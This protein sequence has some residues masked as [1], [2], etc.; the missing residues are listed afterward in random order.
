M[1]LWIED[2][3]CDPVC[4]ARAGLARPCPLP[5]PR[6]RDARRSYRVPVREQFTA[7][8]L[9]GDTTL[10]AAVT[11]LSARGAAVLID[12]AEDGAERLQPGTV[13]RFVFTRRGRARP[14]RSLASVQQ[15]DEPDQGLVRLGLE[16]QRLEELYEQLDPEV[17]PFFNRRRSYRVG[18]ATD[19]EA[20]RARAEGPQEHRRL[21]GVLADL[22]VGGCA[23]AVP[24]EVPV[25]FLPGGGV[26]LRFVPPG[27][28]REVSVAARTVHRRAERERNLVGFAFEP[29]GVPGWPGIE[30]DLQ[31][32]VME[33][34][35][36]ELASGAEDQ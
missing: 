11:D 13:H 14:I 33:V 27:T 16:F 5:L 8:V 9:L 31:R 32:H 2:R 29:E 6:D 3:A 23:L 30:D 17:W 21:E 19:P 18:H 12:P 36:R 28:R 20:P 15:R 25:L 26:E 24:R 35:R 1:T 22:S 34:Q 10:G 7:N 4:R